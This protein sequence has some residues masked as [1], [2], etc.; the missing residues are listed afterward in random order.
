VKVEHRHP[1]GMLQP[2]SIPESKWDVISMDFIVGFPLMA[3]RQDSN[4]LVVYTL[5]KSVHFIPMCMT[6]Q[7]PNI[8]IVFVS[9]IVRLH[10][11]PRRII[12]YQGLVFTGQF[13]T[14]LA[15]N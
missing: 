6:Y 1:T 2:L 15:W 10:G 8:D 7:A 4:F 12:F 14:M 9:D 5:T 13:W 11:V 3:R